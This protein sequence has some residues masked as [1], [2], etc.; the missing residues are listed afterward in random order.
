MGCVSE[1]GRDSEHILR[2]LD[3]PSVDEAIAALAS[4]QH[5]VLALHQVTAVGLTARAVQL[6][7][8]RSRLYRIH[9]NVY[10]LV[11]RSS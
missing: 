1:A 2:F 9:R 8:T 3:Q 10:S 11:P 6:R 7:A 4:G 5:L